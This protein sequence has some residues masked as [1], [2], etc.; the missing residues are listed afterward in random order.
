MQTDTLVL[1][2][3]R[4]RERIIRV[5]LITGKCWDHDYPTAMNSCFS[6]TGRHAQT[7]INPFPTISG[8]CFR[9]CRPWDRDVV[10]VFLGNDSAAERINVPYSRVVHTPDSVPGPATFI[11][12]HMVSCH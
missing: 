2:G 4:V 7:N 1:L 10:G 11:E 12:T 5:H 6:Q 8:V 3:E 9:R